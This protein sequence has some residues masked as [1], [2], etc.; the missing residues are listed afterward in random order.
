V[1][2]LDIDAQEGVTYVSALMW[3]VTYV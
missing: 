2:Y 3:A 1:R